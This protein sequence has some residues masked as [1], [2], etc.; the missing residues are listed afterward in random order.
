M[1][2]MVIHTAEKADLDE[3]VRARMIRN[4]I[5]DFA[6]GFVPF[7]GDIVD[8]FFRANTR[9]AFILYEMLEK[10][11][12]E[13]IEAQKKLQAQQQG[14]QYPINNQRTR[15]NVED[16]SDTDDLGPPP[17]YERSANTQ[18]A[19]PPPNPARPQPARVAEE[20]GGIGGW[21]TRLGSGR[22]D[23]TDLE[24]GQTGAPPP[25]PPRPQR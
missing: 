3:G 12:M 17:Q 10:R 20:R 6:I 7:L 2:L 14:L 24:R 13:N 16:R 5:F 15:V 18:H 22:N 25:Q 9:N 23:Y 19:V 1:A 11:G 21:L 8:A 4:V